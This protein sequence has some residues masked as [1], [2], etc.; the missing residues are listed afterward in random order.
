M[1]DNDQSP[2]AGHSRLA[3]TPPL[4]GQ[5]ESCTLRDQV[6]A[7]VKDWGKGKVY[8]GWASHAIHMMGRN[9]LQRD[10][11]AFCDCYLQHTGAPPTPD[12]LQRAR[13]AA[14][15]FRHSRVPKGADTQ[16]RFGAASITPETLGDFLLLL[17]DRE[18]HELYRGEDADGDA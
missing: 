4:S 3:E 18:P 13:G 7:A 14:V 16:Q 2:A 6:R 5:T 17:N 12:L 8:S 9:T 11:E 1:E 10:L 15:G